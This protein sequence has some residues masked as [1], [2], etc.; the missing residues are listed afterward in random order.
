MCKWLYAKDQCAV[1]SE[2]CPLCGQDNLQGWC[3]KR[4][5]RLLKRIK[6]II[7]RLTRRPRGWT[8]HDHRT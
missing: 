7:E 3:E 5:D 4:T 1:D 2:R 6:S 8:R